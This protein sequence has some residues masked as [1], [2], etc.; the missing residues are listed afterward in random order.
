MRRANVRN[1]MMTKRIPIECFKFIIMSNYYKLRFIVLMVLCHLTFTSR[2]MCFALAS[3]VP[4]QHT[5]TAKLI[6]QTA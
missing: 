4:A 3:F 5:E 1:P 2:L 6:R